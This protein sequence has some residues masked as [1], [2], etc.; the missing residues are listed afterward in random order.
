MEYSKLISFASFD[1]EIAAASLM[2]HCSAYS[3][4][5]SGSKIE[6]EWSCAIVAVFNYAVL[7]W[8]S[9]LNWS[10]NIRRN[11][12]VE[13][14]YDFHLNLKSGMNTSLLYIQYSVF[15]APLEVRFSDLSAKLIVTKKVYSGGLN[16]TVSKLARRN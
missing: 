13:K 15:I 2:V 8:D 10:I 3:S 6:I 14:N 12:Q 1:V 7:S 9:V 4:A 5:S 16:E 11:W